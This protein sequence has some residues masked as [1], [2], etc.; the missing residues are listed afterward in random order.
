MCATKKSNEGSSESSRR[1][2]GGSD[3]VDVH[4]GE[5]RSSG[6]QRGQRL[7]KDFP[8]PPPPRIAVRRES[9]QS[10][11]PTRSSTETPLGRPALLS[12]RRGRLGDSDRDSRCS[13]TPRR[14][15]ALPEKKREKRTARCRER[16]RSA[17]RVYYLALRAGRKEGSTRSLKPTGKNVKATRFKYEIWGR[18]A[19]SLGSRP[20]TVGVLVLLHGAAYPPPPPPPPQG[21]VSLRTEAFWAEMQARSGRISRLAR[22]G[23]PLGPTADWRSPDAY[24]D[25]GPAVMR[26]PRREFYCPSISLLARPRWLRVTR[27]G[28]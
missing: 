10:D 6:T 24:A 27:R 17:I 3:D 1:Q 28:D 25:G 22:L 18:D 7:A 15:K 2:R 26:I 14:T 9:K 21:S 13:Q 8:S 4:Y 5:G 11:G 19:P 23:F 20:S 16:G 12:G